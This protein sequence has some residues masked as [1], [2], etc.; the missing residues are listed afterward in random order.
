M[1]YGVFN[2]GKRIRPVLV[3]ATTEAF[4]GDLDHS[5]AAACAVELIHS[6]SLIHDDLPAMDDD[7]MRRGKPSTHI[8][9]DEATAILAGDA[10][11]S[12]AFAVLARDSHGSHEKIIELA[13]ASG[14]DG[15]V[16][17]QMID[18][19]AVDTILSQNALERMH[20]MKTGALIRASILLGAY[21]Y[22][23]SPEQLDH[24]KSFAH[25]IGLAFQVRD[26]LL[27]AL[28]DES[29]TGKASGADQKRNKPTYV[30]LHGIKG[31]QDIL[32][33]LKERA[34]LALESFDTRANTLR[35]VASFIVA[36]AS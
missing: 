8:Q 5:D 25:N 12:L 35:E 15:M 33:Q 2:G 29:H 23:P 17:G 13:H 31:A 14:A 16:G 19:Q 9:F 6:Y 1:E 32:L 27:D 26:D 20:Q 11:Q 18:I 22:K 21:D 24:L 7:A 10:L 34:M 3:Y 28:G 36:R 4:G 30:S